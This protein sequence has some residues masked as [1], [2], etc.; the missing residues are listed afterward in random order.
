MRSPRDRGANTDL[1]MLDLAAPHTTAR[2][3]RR[4]FEAREVSNW[5]SRLLGGDSGTWS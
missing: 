4:H 3:L 2:S 5:G 1:A